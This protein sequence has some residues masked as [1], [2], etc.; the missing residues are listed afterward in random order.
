MLMRQLNQGLGVRL[1]A[2]GGLGVNKGYQH[3]IWVL[4]Q[5]LFEFLRVYSL[6]PIILDRMPVFQN[7]IPSWAEGIFE[8]S[9]TS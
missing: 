2:S 6:A 9:P 3:R 7:I 8:T 1:S 4:Y 5:S